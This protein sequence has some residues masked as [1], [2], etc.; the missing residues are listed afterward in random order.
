[1]RRD[2]VP[3]RKPEQPAEV[4][5]KPAPLIPVLLVFAPDSTMA[6]MAPTV[7][8]RGVDSAATA[9]TPYYLV[10]TLSGAGRVVSEDPKP[11]ASF[12]AHSVATR[13]SRAWCV[14]PFMHIAQFFSSSYLKLRAAMTLPSSRVPPKRWDTIDLVI[15]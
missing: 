15:L 11:T 3:C 14:Q 9:E 10:P 2:E 6:Q 7:K 1:M 5:E 13:G 12:P 8:N 4:R